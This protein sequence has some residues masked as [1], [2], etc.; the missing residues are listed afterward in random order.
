MRVGGLAK[1]YSRVTGAIRVL[2]GRQAR[3]HGLVKGVGRG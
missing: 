3:V 2:L 1:V